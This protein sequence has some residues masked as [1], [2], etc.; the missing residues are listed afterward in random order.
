MAEDLALQRVDPGTIGARGPE[1]PDTQH[2]DQ[3]RYGYVLNVDLT[4]TI[5]D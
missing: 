1:I 3:T 2:L 4:A 5:L